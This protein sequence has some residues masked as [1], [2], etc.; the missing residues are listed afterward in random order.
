MSWPPTRFANWRTHSVLAR[1]A[2]DLVTIAG[3]ALIL[4][5]LADSIGSFW[6][7]HVYIHPA[8]LEHFAAILLI[9]CWLWTL[10]SAWMVAGIPRRN[11]NR[12]PSMRWRSFASRQAIPWV[13]AL[14]AIIAVLV[15]G[16]TLGAAKGSLRIL[17]GGIHQVST[18]NLNSAQWTT[19]TPSEY[20]HWAA[21][22]IREDAFFATFGLAMAGFTAVIRHLRRK[23][24]EAGL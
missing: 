8:A 20:Q 14:A 4:L 13:A 11:D 12:W 2:D 9:P 16:F 17:P 7:N 18:L 22:F 19:V 5:S 23:L 6:H 21:Q 1:R 24:T 3:I 10:V 15:I